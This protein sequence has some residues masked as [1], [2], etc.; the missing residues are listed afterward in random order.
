MS[1]FRCLSSN[2]LKLI[3]AAAMTA[4]HVGIIFFPGVDIFRIIGR[5]AL[6]IFAFMIAEGC[7]YTRSKPRYLITIASLAAACQVVYYIVSR[8]LY[9]SILVTFSVAIVVI[10]ALQGFKLAL[11]APESQYRMIRIMLSFILFAASVAGAYLLN[12][13][14]EID[15]GFRG[16]MLP[17]AA[18]IFMPPG[19][20]RS[21]PAPLDRLDKIP[22]HVIMMGIGLIPLAC[23]LGGNQWFSLLA[24]PLLL[25]YSGRRGKLKMK[26]FFYVF[27]P[28]HLVILE[29]IDMIV[30]K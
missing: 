29:A 28:A 5:L 27:Y 6:P 2:A 15:Y 14:I 24:L 17:A 19:R 1:K 11:T 20:D 23:W 10:Y 8:S 4:D 12:R 18:S 9:M 30:S 7:R 13:L 3:A 25:C 26:Y 21:L 16:C 22:V